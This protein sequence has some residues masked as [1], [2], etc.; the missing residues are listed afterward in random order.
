MDTTTSRRPWKLRAMTG[1]RY[2]E[3]FADELGRFTGGRV[4]IHLREGARPVFM[5]AR[6]LAYA[7]R[8]PV[9][10]A[11]E[12]LVSDG[13]LTP[14]DRSDW[15]TPIVP[16][17][18]KDGN[19]RICADYK[20]TLNKV[21]DVDRYPLPRVEDLLPRLHGG[22][23]FSKIDLS[24]A[25]AQFVLDDTC[26]CT[27]INTHKGLF[28]YNR[29]VY[30]LASSPGIF[31]RKLEQLFGHIPFV[32]VFLDDIIIS[33]R[34][35]HSHF[36]NLCKVFEILKSSGLKVKKE[37]CS[38]FAESVTYLGYVVSKKGVHTCPDKVK[39]ITNTPAPTNVSELRSLLGM[40]MYYGKFVRN[41]SFILAPLYELLR[42]GVR[43]VWTE[44]C[45]KAFREVKRLLISSEVLVHYSPDLP[46]ILTTDASSL[47]VG[48]VITHTTQHGERPIAYASRSLTKAER[49]YSQIER[50]ALAIIYGVKKF[51]QYLYGRH[52]TLRTDHKPLTSIFGSK[53]GIPIMAASRM[54]RWGVL[55]SGYTYNIEYVP[56]AKNNA[57]ALSRLPLC[58]SEV[59]P[60]NEITYL[61]FVENFLPVTHNDVRKA[62]AAD[63]ISSR[64]LIYT[65]AGWPNQCTDET[66]KSYFVRRNEIYCENNCLMWGYRIIIPMSLRPQ[67]LQQLHSSHMGIVKTKSW[68][69]SYVWWP[70]IDA[71]IEQLCRS[72]STCALE[73]PMP[74]RAPPQL[75]PYIPQPWSRL[76]IDFLGPLHG[77]T[78]FV[79]IDSTSKWL[80]V[81]QMTRTTAGAVVKTLRELFAR[82]GLPVE[83]VSD[84]GP[85]FT[86]SEFKNFLATNGIFQRYS[87]AYHPA[88]NG[89]AENSVKL[90]K[91]VIR[92][93]IIDKTDIDTAL[94]TFL[95]TYRNTIHGTTG[96]TPAQILQRRSLRSRLDL[97]RC[98]RA[99]TDSVR[100][101]QRH[102]TDYAGGKLRHFEPGDPIWFRDYRNQQKWEKGSVVSNSDSRRMSVRES[103]GRQHTKHIDQI[104]RRSRMSDV[105]CSLEE[106]NTKESNN[107]NSATNIKVADSTETVLN[108]EGGG[109]DSSE[110]GV[111]QQPKEIEGSPLNSRHLPNPL[112]P[113]LVQRP[114]RVRKPVQRFNFDPE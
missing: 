49:A 38:F 97:L 30:G 72:C 96:V 52:F 84:Q 57:D 43:F 23:Y 33:G 86:S 20:L 21:L 77:L 70:N 12:Q 109:I 18:K 92:K 48:A 73:M 71:D 55:L 40:V 25:Y 93:A 2:S 105:P 44:N 67:I 106:E 26:N 53:A 31:Q 90:C 74:Q 98:E 94:Q 35:S 8:E 37:K 114:K 56:S 6:P 110:Q 113:P 50:E 85:P 9:E 81:F 112:L 58:Y 15:A 104:R 66:L 80:E 19:I 17:V 75:W 69:R 83:I 4:S 88:S 46:L 24:Q 82:F 79:V 28:R 29:L 32:G 65:Q 54:Q 42:S 100:V 51:H 10:R 102:Q 3:V 34:D 76:H 68:A 27:V 87:P 41:I 5:R 95:L 39:A 108:D 61:N 59:S 62:T 89:A 22:E 107:S 99:V 16:V 47:G 91:N 60:V 111:A 14:V 13:V 36:E 63:T 78:Y 45:D 11:L 1:T 64:L 103:N 101:Q 7:L